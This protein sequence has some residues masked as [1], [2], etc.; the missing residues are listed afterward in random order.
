MKK[1]R[2]ELRALQHQVKV[3]N[4]ISNISLVVSIII[5]IIIIVIAL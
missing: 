4:R 5:F 1:H 2:N 3:M